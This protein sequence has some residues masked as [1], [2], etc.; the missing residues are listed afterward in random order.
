MRRAMA[1][2][3]TMSTKNAPGK[4]KPHRARKSTENC[5]QQP[6]GPLLLGSSSTAQESKLKLRPPKVKARFM[7]TLLCPLPQKRTYAQERKQ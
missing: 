7:K 5:T 2:I 6:L 4:W 1:T 3:A